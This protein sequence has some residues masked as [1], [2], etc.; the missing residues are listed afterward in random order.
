MAK[1]EAI[2]FFE[3]EHYKRV[4]IEAEDEKDAFQKLIASD[5]YFSD[6]NQAINMKNVTSFYFS[7]P[8]K[9]SSST[10]W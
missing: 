6:D 2:I 10:G 7:K 8:A 3:K 4:K 1:H 5:W 9:V